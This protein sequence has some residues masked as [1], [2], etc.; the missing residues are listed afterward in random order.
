M[1]RDRFITS[2]GSSIYFE[3]SGDGP[4]VLALHGIGGGAYFFRALAGRLAPQSRLLAVDLPGVGR[5][6]SAPQAFTL[7][8]WLSDLADFV[9]SHLGEPVVIVGHSL[10]TILAL[11]AWRRWPAHVRAM[12][13]IGGLPEV[14][15][16]IRGRLSVRLA[17]IRTNGLAG[18]GERAMA[19]VFANES[20]GRRAEVV[21]L[22]ERLFETQPV[23]AYARCI[24][25]LL[26]ANATD[27]VGTVSVPCLALT[28]ADDQ[29]APPDLVAAFAE[30]LG[31]PRRT[32]VVTACGHLPFFEAPDE[33][34]AAMREFLEAPT[35]GRDGSSTVS[36]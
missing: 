29:Y 23:D 20:L 24:E 12:A 18:W 36:G 35:G 32:H 15:P 26:A 10:G 31:G 7:E 34:A 9:T 13:F 16:M 19:G 33:L 21:G 5:S 8:T 4:P 27:V 14:R 30:Q 17:D 3:D 28:G 11:E 25:I 6:T 1:K 22:Y 2:A